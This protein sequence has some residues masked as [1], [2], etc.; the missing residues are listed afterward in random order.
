MY[1]YYILLSQ[2]LIEH[3]PK[4]LPRGYRV[5]EKTL[6]R[7]LIRMYLLGHAILIGIVVCSFFLVCPRV[8]L[9]SVECDIMLTVRMNVIA[10]DM[11]ECMAN[12]IRINYAG[13]LDVL[14]VPVEAPIQACQVYFHSSL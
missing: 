3:P 12:R 1:F 14:Q 8:L 13:I 6:T 7:T 9:A 11:Y 10:N 2:A 4:Y 5:T